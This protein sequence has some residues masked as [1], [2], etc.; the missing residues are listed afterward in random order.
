MLSIVFLEVASPI[1]LICKK[2]A[3]KSKEPELISRGW[4]SSFQAKVIVS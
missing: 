2:V 1:P 4:F 3:A